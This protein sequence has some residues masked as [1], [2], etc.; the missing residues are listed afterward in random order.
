MNFGICT[1]LENAQLLK[2]MG[3]DYI[4]GSL[5]TVAKMNRDE[6]SEKL[7]LFNDYGIKM[8][9]TNMFFPGDIKLA[10]ESADINKIKDYICRA[11]DN[12]SQFGVKTCVLGSGNARRIPDESDY[13]KGYEQVLEAVK[14]AGEIAQQ[15]EITIAIE[16]L[17]LQETNIFTTVKESLEACKKINLENVCVLAD[18]YHMFVEK[19]DFSILP[20]AGEKLCHIHFC[21]PVERI[22]PS[23][24]DSYDYTPF[25]SALK[26]AG[27]KGKISV[28][29]RSDDIAKDGV[30]ALELLKQIFCTK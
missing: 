22:Y 5:S 14:V 25:I 20:A 16:P 29:A 26:Q 17:N 30:K 9:V 13:N 8:N 23:I 4:E 10:G 19:E 2:S 18:L 28:E 15:Y 12:A 21:N 1:G 27:Y 6:I 7:K 11:F 3:F 24:T